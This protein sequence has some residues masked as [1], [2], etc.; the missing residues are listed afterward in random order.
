MIKIVVD[1]MG[2]DNAPNEI[3]KGA[4]QALAK[5]KELCVLLTGD[6]E[7]IE[8]V[9]QA[10]GKKDAYDASRLEIVHCTEVI[11]NDDAPTLAIRQKKDSSLVV[12]LKAL[13]EDEQTQGFVSAG[14]TGAV[15][16][17][18]LLRVGRIRGISRP[19]VC[20]VL[21]TAK[22][23][24]VLLIDAGANAECKPVNLCHFALMGT[25]YARASGIAEPRVGL[26][27]NGTEDHKGDPLHQEAHEL[28]KTLPGIR[29]VGNVE[30]R[31]I[32][33]GEIDV[34]VCD[35]FSGNIA[36]KTTEGTALAV[37]QIIKQNIMASFWAKV[38]Y[39]LFMKKAFKNI[40]RVMDY[41]KYGGA[42]LL[43]IDKVV[44]K[45]HG[46]SK[47]DSIC[48][49]VLQAKAAAQSGLVPSIKQMLE[50]VDLEAIGGEA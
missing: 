23:G 4:L 21:P 8:A 3:V 44:V 14:S 34:A 13:K 28:L 25:A 15:L 24:K 46:S 10:E 26:V 32:M 30:G 20:P 19:A 37:M 47:A 16:T 38:G 27:T 5:D 12:A 17:G 36:L 9:L 42:V 48:A 7:K 43:G 29:F 35:G 33:S 2:G 6:R 11:T 41:S 50:K 22:G 31:D 39:A 1:A 40:K 18:A 45:S 49:S